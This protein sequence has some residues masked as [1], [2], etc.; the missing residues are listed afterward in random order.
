MG[1]KN[2]KKAL[3]KDIEALDKRMKEYTAWEKRKKKEEKYIRTTTGQTEIVWLPKQ[4]SIKS[5]GNLVY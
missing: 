4:H 3:V 5:K 1:K 2:R